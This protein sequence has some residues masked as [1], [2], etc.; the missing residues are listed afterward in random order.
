M[1]A[2]TV[3]VTALAA[4]GAIRLRQVAPAGAP[5]TVAIVQADV[6]GYDRLAAE[7]GRFETVRQVLDTHFG[8]T[9]EALRRGS[10]DLVVWPETVY[11][12]TFGQPKSPDGA[13]FDRAIAAFVAR[14]R[15]PLVF[16]AYDVEDGREFNAAIVLTP[17]REGRVDF[18]AYRKTALFP[19]TERVPAGLG[20]LR[21]WLPW[22]GTWTT[23][24][25]CTWR[26]SSATTPSIRA[27][28]Q[29]PCAGAPTCSSHS[30]T[31]R[32]SR[33]ASVRGSISWS[34][35]SAASR[36]AGRRCAPPARASRP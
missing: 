5:L 16:G 2:V 9:S 27:W 13:A 33:P 20:F 31:T 14:E 12:T 17:G 3:I 23:G 1:L 8:L 28:P 6:A 32:G 35:P 4:Y 30:R 18:A 26:R 24:D 25:G 15:V 7:Q 22:L 29:P 36:R 34:P 19:L 11:P 21:G 10:T